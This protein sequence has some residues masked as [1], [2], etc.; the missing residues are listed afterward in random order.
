MFATHHIHL[1]NKASIRSI[2]TQISDHFP[3]RT[4]QDKVLVRIYQQ[5]LDERIPYQGSSKASRAPFRKGL[6]IL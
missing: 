3:N 6:F 4:Y 1:A 2:R 5:V